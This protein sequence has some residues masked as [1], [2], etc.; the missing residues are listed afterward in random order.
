VAR[1]A[2]PK[3][4]KNG[5]GRGG[6]AARAAAMLHT[7]HIPHRPTRG[8]SSHTQRPRLAADLANGRR[9][10]AHVPAAS[11]C[12][13]QLLHGRRLA[14]LG[15]GIRTGRWHG[16][17]PGLSSRKPTA[18]A[19]AAAAAAACQP[20]WTSPPHPPMQVE[21]CLEAGLEA[22]AWNSATSEQQ[23]TN[24]MSEIVS[25]EPDLQLLYTTP[26]SLLKL[27]LRDALKVLAGRLGW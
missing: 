12:Q 4:Q 20:L 23:R 2:F 11:R 10:V 27:G 19:A 17:H 21:K 24:I 16:Q 25:S 1:V 6:V 9:Q 7:L 13:G 3:Q 22:A 8:H 15:T 18:Y 5:S 14:P 26:E